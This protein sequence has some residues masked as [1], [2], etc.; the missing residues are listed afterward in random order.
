MGGHRQ[1]ESFLLRHATLSVTAFNKRL[2]QKSDQVGC[3]LALCCSFAIIFGNPIFIK[4]PVTELSKLFVQD[5]MTALSLVAFPC[6]KI[7]VSSAFYIVKTKK[8]LVTSEIMYHKVDEQLLPAEGP[9]CYLP[10]PLVQKSPWSSF[11]SS[12]FSILRIVSLSTTLIRSNSSGVNH[13][14]RI[15][16]SVMSLRACVGY[17]RVSTA[18]LTSNRLRRGGETGQISLWS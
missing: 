2:I 8:S 11:S 3:Y 1:R 9:R 14:S 10:R 12:D 17:T 6:Y 18:N 4:I 15:S 5:G 13:V 16:S 7:L